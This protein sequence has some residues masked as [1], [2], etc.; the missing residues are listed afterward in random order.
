VEVVAEGTS[1]D[2]AGLGARFTNDWETLS[3]PR[4]QLATDSGN[5]YASLC[6]LCAMLVFLTGNCQLTLDG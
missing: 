3:R 5:S 1:V 6:D 4:W 2:A